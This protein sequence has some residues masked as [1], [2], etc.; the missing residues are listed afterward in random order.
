M[1]DVKDLKKAKQFSDA[2]QYEQKHQLL[3][4][5]VQQAP[6]EFYVDSDSR[7]ILGLTHELTGFKIHVPKVVMQGVK[8][9]N[10]SKHVDSDAAKLSAAANPLAASSG[11][12]NIT[13]GGQGSYMKMPSLFG[14]MKS[15]LTKATKQV[16]EQAKPNQLG[17]QPK[18]KPNSSAGNLFPATTKHMQD[19]FQNPMPFAHKVSALTTGSLSSGLGY[20]P[21]FWYNQDAFSPA[22]QTR[23]GN[24]ISGLG[25]S[26]LGLLSIPALQYLFPE[27]F[28]GKGKSLAALSVLGGMAAPWILNAGSTA[29]DIAGLSLPKNDKYTDADWRKMQ[30]KSRSESGVIPTGIN[31]AIA[32]GK[33]PYSVNS[34]LNAQSGAPTFNEAVQ[35]P[36]SQ[37]NAGSDFPFKNRSTSS[38]ITPGYFVGGHTDED[39]GEYVGGVATDSTHTKALNPADQP[40]V[41]QIR[42]LRESM[43]NVNGSGFS[44]TKANAYIPMDLEIAKS[45]LANVTAQQMQS[46]YVDYGQAAGLMLRAGQESKKPWVTVRDIA[47]A[48]IGAGAGAIAGTIAAKGIGMFANLTPNERTALQGTGAALGTLINLGKLGI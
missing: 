34:G 11:M 42:T 24:I 46:G 25:L 10:K 31:A 12:P 7:G 33:N 4:Q 9:Q 30:I 6:D 19:K 20:S 3:Y 28:K 17:T 14:N 35:D 27:R 43:A 40:R 23:A 39:T 15:Q 16:G 1:T 44:R 41:D 18:Q 22:G 13:G 47:N 26:G 45:H 21:G 2:K 8:L 37:Y 29:A 5:L 38:K 48:A 32:E 36:T